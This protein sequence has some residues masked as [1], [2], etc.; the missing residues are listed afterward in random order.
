MPI[1]Q[2]QRCLPTHPPAST[3]AACCCCSAAGWVL[4]RAAPRRLWE[5][6]GGK[7]RGHLNADSLMV[8]GDKRERRRPRRRPAHRCRLAGT[9]LLSHGS[10]CSEGEHSLQERGAKWE[11]QQRQ[12]GRWGRPRLRLR[13]SQRPP[14]PMDT[15]LRPWRAAQ[16]LGGPRKLAAALLLVSRARCCSLMRSGRPGRVPEIARELPR[17]LCRHAHVA[18]PALGGGTPLQRSHPACPLLSVPPANI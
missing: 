10:C 2:P 6:A 9:S 18:L 16:L 7:S 4:G 17:S 5:T 8:A 11:Q 3:A 1:C 15:H 14:A 12:V 13:R